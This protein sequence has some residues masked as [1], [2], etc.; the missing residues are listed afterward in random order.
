MLGHAAIQLTVDTYGRWLPMGKKASVGKLDQGSTMPEA[1]A[2]GQNGSILAADTDSQCS[3]RLQV[4]VGVGDPPGT[5]TPNLEI[6]SLL[7][8]Q[9]S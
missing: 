1:V 4:V 9:L 6:K 2:V 8:Y 3:G 7:L 5:R